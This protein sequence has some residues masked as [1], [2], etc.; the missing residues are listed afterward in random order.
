M[1]ESASEDDD[2]EDDNVEDW[3]DEQLTMTN[4]EK[5]KL[6]EDI[7]PVRRVLVKV[8]VPSNTMTASSTVMDHI[9]S[10][11]LPTR[12]KTHRPSFYHTGM[13]PSKN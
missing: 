6:D 4:E 7:Q 1:K 5:Q 11:R 8:S 9:S 12:S 3:V 13:L 2:T 10:K